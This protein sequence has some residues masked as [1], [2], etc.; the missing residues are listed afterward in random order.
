LGVA[1]GENKRAGSSLGETEHVYNFKTDL[2][3]LLTF[4]KLLETNWKKNV[5]LVLNELTNGRSAHY[6]RKFLNSVQC[7]NYGAK[8]S[9]KSPGLLVEWLTRLTYNPKMDPGFDPGQGTYKNL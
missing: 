2:K 6:Q 7:N 8:C 5:S 1:V 9:C 3:N 4:H